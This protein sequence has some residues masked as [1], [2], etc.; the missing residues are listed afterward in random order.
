M[1]KKVLFSAV[2]LYVTLGFFVLP[3]ILK[4]QL[5][6]IV[7]EKTYASLGIEDIYFNPFIFNLKISGLSLKSKKDSQPLIS[8]KSISCDVELYS[9]L[10][11]TINIKNFTLEEPHLFVTFYKDKTL[12]LLRIL[13]DA[14]EDLKTKK[15]EK[16][17]STPPHIIIKRVAIVNGNLDYVDLTHKSRFDFSFNHIGFELKNIDTNN[18]NNSN[19]KV[20]FYST[21]A[22][23]GFIDLKTDIVG[24]KPMKLKGSLNFEASKLYTQWRYLQDN[25]NF[26]VADGKIALDAKYTLNLDNLNDMVIDD[27]N[28]YLDRLRIKPKDKYKDILNLKHLAITDLSIKPF[29]KKIDLKDIILDG[30]SIK[31]MKDQN[32]FID[33]LGYI[34]T[35][36]QTKTSDKN[37]TKKDNDLSISLKNLALKNIDVEFND[38]YIKPNVQTKL[39]SFNLYMKDITLEG[40]KP[41]TY[42][43]DMRLNDNFRCSSQG[44]IIHKILDVKSQ[45]ECKGFNI[46]HYKPYIDDVANKS[47][48]LYNLDLKSA[49]LDFDFNSFIKDVDNNLTINI[50]DAN[51]SLNNF[52]LN[53]KS[54]KERVIDFKEFSINGIDVDTKKEIVAIKNSTLKSLNLK[55]KIYKNKKLNLENLVIAKESKKSKKNQKNNYKIN[56][57]HFGLENAKIS[58]E[59]NSITKKVNYMLDDIDV[60]LYDLNSSKKSWLN[61]KASMKINKKGS[62]KTSGKFSHTPLKQKS[63]LELKNI[64][65]RELTPYLQEKAFIS[66]SSGKLNLKTKIDYTQNSQ[67]PDLVLN[68]GLNLKNIVIDDLRDSSTLVAFNDLSL[69]SFTFEMFPNRLFIDEVNLK[70]FYLNAMIDANKTMNLATLMKKTKTIKKD[71]NKTQNS[72]FPIK[73]VKMN[74]I[75][76]NAK[77]ADLSLPIKFRTNIHDLSGSVYAISNEPKETTFIDIVG[78]VDKYGSTK[79][80]GS[81]N[82]SNPKSFTDIAFN[83]KN[84]ALNSYSGYSV[85]FAGYKIDS[86]KLFLDL[87]YDI[88]NSNLKSKNNLI[89]KNIKLGE[90]L[91]EDTLPIGFVIALLEDSD[92]VIDIDMPIEGNVDKPDFKYGALVVKTLGNLVVKAVTSP[93]R[94]LGSLMGIDAKDLESIDFEAGLVTI[95]PSEKEKL[96]AIAKMMIKRPKIS[97]SIATTYDSKI[98]KK[99]LQ[100]QKL[101]DLVAKISKAKNKEKHITAMSIDILEGIYLKHKDKKSLELIKSELSKQYKDDK[102]DRAYLVKVANEAISMQIVTLDELEKLA[103]ERFKILKDYLVKEKMIKESRVI[104]LA[105]KNTTNSENGMIKSLIEIE[106]K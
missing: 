33:W 34:K 78:K 67:K 84:L 41:I 11:S 58:F 95:L 57:K 37:E 80:K 54:T 45:V 87:K 23:G 30:L 12:N 6:K 17:K 10:N 20:R 5:I 50:V 85:S 86:G 75:N 32:G 101:I 90:A 53:K 43:L 29:L 8:L 28:I 99:A 25:L 94:F 13:K 64:S 83:F 103:K 51:V 60:D 77:F 44:S 27:I 73:I 16:Q 98:D 74:I 4:S 19:A 76:G 72:K 40:S 69:K 48:K 66:L 15:S 92:G 96:D 93:F 81:L 105:I 59:D 63:T 88:L 97:L 62:L 89:I 1:F 36:N 56:L 31:I 22:D 47:L 24:F 9:L 61:Y 21:L 70:E 55:A 3:I 35:N 65:L 52:A 100:K 7:D 26:E 14:K 91:K 18:F 104:P 68:G 39:N 46:V 38:N 42:K 102:L 106:V 49:N 79:L 82:A 2:V 71:N